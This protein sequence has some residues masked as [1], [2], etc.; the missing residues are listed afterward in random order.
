M[1]NNSQNPSSEATEL[2][3]YFS[4]NKE[5]FTFFVGLIGAVKL[6]DGAPQSPFG[7]VFGFFMLSAA[8]WIGWRLFRN[9]PKLEGITPELGAFKFC[10]AFAVGALGCYVS[11]RY[12]T[13]A[14]DMMPALTMLAIFGLFEVADR[15]FHLRAWLKRQG[16]QYMEAVVA[17]AIWMLV[18]GCYL[19][20]LLNLLFD[21]LPRPK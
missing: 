4:V 11:W 21:A 6:F 18:A 17:T 9:C 8:T 5:K 16:E 19:S 12:R 10:M 14:R 7:Y 3:D 2:K 15:R 1:A 20:S 13:L